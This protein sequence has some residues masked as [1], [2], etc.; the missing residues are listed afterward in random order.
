MGK[1]GRILYID[2][3]NNNDQYNDNK[4]NYKSYDK[5]INDKYIGKYAI[6]ELDKNGQP[7]HEVK[8]VP[9]NIL[10]KS[11]PDPVLLKKKIS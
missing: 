4:Y 10:A 7:Y 8:Y 11:V 9:M 2:D 1:T 6:I 3:T 5:H